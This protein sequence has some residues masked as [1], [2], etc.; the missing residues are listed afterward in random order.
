VSHILFLFEGSTIAP[1]FF[2]SLLREYL[3][4][5]QERQWAHACC[6]WPATMRVYALT[7]T[8]L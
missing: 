2:I 8:V 7:C 5:D 3:Y 1:L 6:S 4:L